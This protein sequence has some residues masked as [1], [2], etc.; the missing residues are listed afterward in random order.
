[1]SRAGTAVALARL[2]LRDRSEL[3]TTVV[4]PPPLAGV[5]SLSPGG[6][7]D[8]APHSLFGRDPARVVL[9]LERRED[10][11]PK[12]TGRDVDARGEFVSDLATPDLLGAL[13]ATAAAHG[14]EEGEPDALGL[15]TGPSAQ[16][17][18][19]RVADAP[20]A[21]ECRRRVSLSFSPERSI[22]V[23][24]AVALHARGG[25]VD[26]GRM[27]V[28][29]GGEMPVARLFAGRWARLVEIERRTVPEPLRAGT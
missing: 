27:H 16:A 8:A 20:V 17:A 5:T 23:G 22:L 19:P 26:P 7:A 10:G 15:A 6:V 12:D 2:A 4:I 18:P 21:L 25:M 28:D 24:E 9:G 11:G 14:P 1:M 3:P 29:R 13:V